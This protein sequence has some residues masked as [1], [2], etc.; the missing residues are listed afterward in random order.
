MSLPIVFGVSNLD[1]LNS[2]NLEIQQSY[3][4]RGFETDLSLN[5][6]P[7]SPPPKNLKFSFFSARGGGREGYSENR[8]KTAAKL[9]GAWLCRISDAGELRDSRFLGRT[10]TQWLVLPP[11]RDVRNMKE[12]YDDKN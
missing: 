8:A 10:N 7:I 4:G 11:M 6:L 5:S 9:Y 2:P 1:S 3:T 12:N